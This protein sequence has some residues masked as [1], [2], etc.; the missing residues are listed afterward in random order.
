MFRI[1]NTD[2]VIDVNVGNTRWE[3][4]QAN[5]VCPRAKKK[6]ADEEEAEKYAQNTR[7]NKRVLTTRA[8]IEGEDPSRKSQRTEIAGGGNGED[9]GGGE[10]E[11]GNTD[12]EMG[13]DVRR[14][15]RERG[16][17]LVNG[18]EERERDEG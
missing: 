5:F 7:A 2:N 12:A 9:N 16:D 3:Y 15:L 1:D 11:A 14:G 13:G 17:R 18:A 6:S 10:N 4:D 8:T